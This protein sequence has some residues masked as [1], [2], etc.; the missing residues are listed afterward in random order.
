MIF[1]QQFSPPVILLF[2][3]L[4]ACAASQKKSD[5]M[6][7]YELPR[8]GQAAAPA[9]NDSYYTQPAV[10]KWCGNISEAPSCGGG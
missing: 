1:R 6:D 3:M 5:V 4:S 2:C 7:L 10:Y 9:D 8:S